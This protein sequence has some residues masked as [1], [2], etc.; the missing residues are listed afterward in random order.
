MLDAQTVAGLA[1]DPFGN[2]GTGATPEP[3]TLS[4]LVL[5][6]AAVVWKRRR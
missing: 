6:L 1:R 2:I 3:G 5:G 4:A